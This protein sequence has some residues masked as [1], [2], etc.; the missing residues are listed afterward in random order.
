MSSRIAIAQDGQNALTAPTKDLL[1][2]TDFNNLKIWRAR[3]VSITVP[4][5]GFGFG[6]A[7]IS[8]SHG[9][10]YIPTFQVFHTVL[11]G[12][13]TGKVESF[14]SQGPNNFSTVY[15]TS[16]DIVFRLKDFESGTHTFYFIIFV[17]PVTTGSRSGALASNIRIAKDGF[18]A[19]TD[20][21]EVNYVFLSNR[22]VFNIH[23]KSSTSITLSSSNL[24]ET[25]TISHGLGYI[26]LAIVQEINQ[27][28]K[29]P[30]FQGNL[31]FNYYLDSSNIYI[32]ALQVFTTDTIP[33][34]FRIQIFTQ[35]YGENINL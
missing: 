18:N 20:D 24:E 33:L 3:Q 6:N 31:G 15:T 11:S 29:A 17:D 7:T 4:D 23:Q 19:L 26:P 22:P 14:V 8:Y 10:A 9:L 21:N 2:S 13:F 28:A 35:E 34:D 5:D 32:Y 25:K 30:Y 27:G 16:S 1:F 12:T